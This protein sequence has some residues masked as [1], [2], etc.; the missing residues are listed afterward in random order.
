MGQ[1]DEASPRRKFRLEGVESLAG[2]AIAN[3]G[4]PQVDTPRTERAEETGVLDVRRDDL[5]ERTE[6]KAG[7]DRVAPLRRR[8]RERD[9]A[10]GRCPDEFGERPAHPLA[11]VSQLLPVGGP[12]AALVERAPVQLCHHVGSAARERPEGPRVQVRDV[13]EDG[14]LGTDGAKIYATTASTGA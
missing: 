5:V 13:G 11:Q 12:G 6:T 8:G 14:E 10:V 3:T 9:R 1:S 2:G 7:D 4:Y